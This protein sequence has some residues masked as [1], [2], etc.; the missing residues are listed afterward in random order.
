[1]YRYHKDYLEE[2]GVYRIYFTSGSITLSKRKLGDLLDMTLKQIQETGYKLRNPYKIENDYVVVYCL[3]K[4]KE[5]VSVKMDYDIWFKY[6]ECYFSCTQTSEYPMIFVGGKRKN[7]HRIVMGMGDVK[8][9]NYI[10]VDHINKDICDARK[11]NLRIVEQRLNTKNQGFF[12]EANKST[13]IRGVTYTHKD[14]L[15]KY[16]TRIYDF[17]GKLEIEYFNS[18]KEAIRYNYERRKELG[19]LFWEGSTTIENYIENI[20][21]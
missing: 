6:K 8:F 12:N 15:Y 14:K 13:G 2:E 11:K 19:Y 21:E 20:S 5:I 17:D 10:V 9:D 1:M 7:L 4:A 18:L 16:R 3:N